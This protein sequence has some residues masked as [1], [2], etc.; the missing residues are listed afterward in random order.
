MTTMRSVAGAVSDAAGGEQSAMDRRRRRVSPC[1][2][3]LDMFPAPRFQLIYAAAG[4]DIRGSGGRLEAILDGLDGAAWSTPSGAAGWTVAD[5]VLHL[6]QTEE[7]VAEAAAG[8]RD[9]WVRDGQ[10]L[11]GMM[12]RWVREERAAPEAVFQRWRTARRA[13]LDALRRADPDR[14]LAWA[15]AALTPK[16]LATTR[17]A[18]HWAHGLD[19]T[20]PL[21]IPFPDTLRLRRARVLP[22]PA[23]RQPAVG[24]QD[25][26]PLAPDPAHLAAGTP[27]GAAGGLPRPRTCR[28]AGAAW[29]IN[30]LLLDVRHLRRMAP[31][32]LS[33]RS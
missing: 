17:L 16:A 15:A 22:P 30:H 31:R 2:F 27:A 24:G 32:V 1:P 21:V 4:G 7:A 12:D 28:P 10:L 18:E 5:V 19:I 26:A 14:P 8:A 9:R 13:A 25:A 33:R 23:E 6:A 11:D 29:A 3:H 20:G